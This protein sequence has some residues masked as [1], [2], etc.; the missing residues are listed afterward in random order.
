MKM[1]VVDIIGWAGAIAVLYAY[2]IVSLNKVRGDSLHFQVFNIIGAIGL[3]IHT[4]FN[5]A[6]P[7]TVV[8]IIWIGIAIYSLVVKKAEV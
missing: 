2:F 7:S 4:Y 1:V 6:Y 8:N 3:C 5:H